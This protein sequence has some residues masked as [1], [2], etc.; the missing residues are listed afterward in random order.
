MRLNVLPIINN[1]YDYP[2]LFYLVF[3]I[4]Y[5]FEFTTNLFCRGSKFN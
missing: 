2:V 5:F 4:Y 3:T 1:K